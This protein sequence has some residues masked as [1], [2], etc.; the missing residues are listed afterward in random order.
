MC[1]R[2]LHTRVYIVGLASHI[3]RFQ[4]P[5]FVEA[6]RDETLL[7]KRREGRDRQ[8]QTTANNRP[9]FLPVQHGISHRRLIANRQ[10]QQPDANS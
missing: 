1:R 3:S 7:R 9:S 10:Q 5:G 4:V 6:T 2:A 8:G